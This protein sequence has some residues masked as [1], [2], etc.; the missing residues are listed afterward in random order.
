MSELIFS[1]SGRLTHLICG[2]REMNAVWSAR[3]TVQSM[4]DV[5]AA[6]ARAS[7]EHG[8]IPS[9]AVAAIV[10]ACNADLIDPD[11]AKY[12]R[13]GA[14]SQDIIDTGTVLQLRSMFDL[15]EA[16]LNETCDALANQAQTYRT[17]PAIGRT[18]LQQALPITLGLKFAQWLDALIRHRERLAQCRSRVLALQ[19]GGAAGMLAS[20]RDKA[21]L[22]TQ[23]LADDLRLQ[24]PTLP[25]HTQR[26]RIA[27][28]AACFGMLTGTLGKIAR[29][30]S[31]Q[32]QTEVGELAEPAAAGKRAVHQRCRT[33]ATRSAV[34]PCS[35]PR[36][37]SRIWSRPCSA[38]WFRN[39]NARSAAGRLN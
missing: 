10:A 6:L 4:L 1:A 7:A 31:L 9:S 8:V 37:A 36:C 34:Q 23:S 20:L 27:E 38:A 35:P 11:A 22:V 39:M 16:G 21:P 5:E 17:M 2:T 18:W 33:S 25:W 12:V 32:M 24:R 13:W 3:Q 26:D 15:L 14:T 30:I 28:A 19:F 29:D